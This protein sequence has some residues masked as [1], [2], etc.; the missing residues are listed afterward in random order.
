METNITKNV[1]LAIFDIYVLAE[2]GIPVFAGCSTSDYCAS[3]EGQ[4]PLHAGFIHAIQNF[5]NEVFSSGIRDLKF[6]SVKLNFKSTGQYTIVFV[7]PLS[8]SDRYIHEKLEEVSELFMHK[9]EDK[10]QTHLLSDELYHEFMD[11]IVGIGLI[12]KDRIK[13]T[14]SIFVSESDKDQAK[15]GKSIFSRFKQ[16]FI[17]LVRN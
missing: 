2:G 12:A 11:D 5:G 3:H 6:D 4:H 10:V 13:S 17:N 9:Y 1:G 8:T 7:N 14:K 15:N 16:K